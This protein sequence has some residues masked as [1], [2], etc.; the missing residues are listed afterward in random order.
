MTA[1]TRNLTGKLLFLGTGTSVSRP[2]SSGQVSSGIWFVSV[3]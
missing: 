3:Q 2:A 1:A